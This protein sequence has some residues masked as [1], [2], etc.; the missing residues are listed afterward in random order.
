M[1]WALSPRALQNGP[2]LHAISAAS[3]PKIHD[4]NAQNLANTAWAI[5]VRG[6]LNHE[7]LIH[8]ISS[9]AR[10]LCLEGG[11]SHGKITPVVIGFW[12]ASFVGSCV[13]VFEHVQRASADFDGPAVATLLMDARWRRDQ[14]ADARLWEHVEQVVSD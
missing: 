3:I 14:W 6:V 9:S 2:L 7:P 1:A 11:E 10:R 12:S 13:E 8:A 4:F 5:A